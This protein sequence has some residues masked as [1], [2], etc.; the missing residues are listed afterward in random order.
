MRDE[1]VFVEEVNAMNR[2]VVAF[3]GELHDRRGATGRLQSPISEHR[4]FERLVMD[5]NV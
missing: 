1:T 3:A 2:I 5:A 4:D